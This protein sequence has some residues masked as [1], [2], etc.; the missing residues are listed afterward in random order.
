MFCPGFVL[1]AFGSRMGRKRHQR[2]SAPEAIP[3]LPILTC[4]RSEGL[5]RRGSIHHDELWPVAIEP[6]LDRFD[7][8]FMN[9][10]DLLF[11]EMSTPLLHSGLNVLGRESKQLN[12]GRL[13]TGHT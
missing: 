10:V 9:V 11:C 8:L 13:V 3:V 1:Y 5:F 12:E 4:E 6:L 7:P 2:W